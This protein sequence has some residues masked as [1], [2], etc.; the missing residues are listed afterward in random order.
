MRYLISVSYDGAKLYGFE[1]QPRKKTVQG[2][3]ERVLTKINKTTVFVKG[4]GRTDRGVH[5]YDQK[6][7]FDLNINITCD[8]LKRAMNSMLDPSVYVN[9]VKTVDNEFHARFDVKEKE[10]I[11]KVNVGEYNPIEMDYVYQYNK[12]LDIKKMKEAASFLIG[13]HDFSS[14]TTDSKEYE[15]CVREIFSIDIK[16]D[17]NII[18]F[19]FKGNGFLRYMVRN[20]VGTL[21][22]VGSNKIE[23][24]KIESILLSKDRRKAGKSVPG[25]GLYLNNV[26]Y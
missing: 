25:G 10:Y 14:F 8:G 13:E 22:D 15:T 12:D 2:E 19:I 16:Q 9:S 4:A 24:N 21:I 6:V 11:Y 7:H 17:D 3:L 1:R 23:P 26:K 5:A 20:I 18:T